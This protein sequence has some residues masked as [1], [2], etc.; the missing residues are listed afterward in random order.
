MRWI[1]IKL[2]RRC[3]PAVR[4]QDIFPEASHRCTVFMD[5]P[6]ISAANPILTRIIII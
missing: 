5:T 3:P 2:A 4:V 6:I 1:S